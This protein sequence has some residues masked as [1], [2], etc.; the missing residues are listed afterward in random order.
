MSLGTTYTHLTVHS[1]QSLLRLHPHHVS[2]YLLCIYLSI[3][4]LCT[5]HIISAY[6][7]PTRPITYLKPSYPSQLSYHNILSILPLLP[8]LIVPPYAFILIGSPS[9]AR[10]DQYDTESHHRPYYPNSLT[11]ASPSASTTRRVDLCQR[12][13]RVSS[14]PLVHHPLSQAILSDAPNVARSPLPVL[15]LAAS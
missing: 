8:A 10:P 12:S 4:L 7:I 5:Q 14:P 6:P 2:H 3:Y 13:S 11:Q 9:P 15:Q 1:Y